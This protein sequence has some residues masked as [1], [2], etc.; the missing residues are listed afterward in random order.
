MAAIRPEIHTGG[1]EAARLAVATGRAT[2]CLAQAVYYEARGESPTG[3][4]AVAQVV[5]NRVHHPAFPKSVCAVVFQR[6]GDACQFSFACNGAMRE[7]VDEDAWRRA[8]QVAERAIGGAIMRQVGAAT[9]FQSTRVRDSGLARS[10]LQVAHIGAH[11]FYR[12]PS[13]GQPSA[14][15]HLASAQAEGG[16]IHVALA[17]F[18]MSAGAPSTPT[19]ARADTDLSGSSA[20]GPDQPISSAAP[21]L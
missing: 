20:S 7:A 15:T 6:A 12:L 4:A 14:A 10:L 21:A 13:P 19:G 8:R 5:L 11:I 16:R 1:M 9:I 17:E 3:Q 2:Q 18:T